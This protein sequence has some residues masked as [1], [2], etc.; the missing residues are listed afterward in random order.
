MRTP[1]LVL[2]LTLAAAPRVVAEGATPRPALDPAE[3]RR[4]VERLDD[5]RFAVRQQADEDLRRLGAGVMALLEEELPRAASLE[6]SVRLGRILV[7]LGGDERRI[8][9]LVKELAAPDAGRRE[10]AAALLQMRGMDVL[11]LLRKHEAEA[12]AAGRRRL[13][14]VIRAIENDD[15]NRFRLEF[16]Y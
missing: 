1:L 2:A 15:L 16:V 3:V 9:L 5:D 10:R 14:A 4:L 6:V 13:Q 7:D 8:R 12:D 11:P